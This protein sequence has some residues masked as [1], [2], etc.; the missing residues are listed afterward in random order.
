MSGNI[1]LI[2]THDFTE[3]EYLKQPVESIKSKISFSSLN[4]HDTLEEILNINKLLKLRKLKYLLSHYL[5]IHLLIFQ[6]QI[7][8]LQKHT[9]YGGS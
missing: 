3:F 7:K 6:Y 8:N 5:Q 1:I 2:T 9:I 4:D